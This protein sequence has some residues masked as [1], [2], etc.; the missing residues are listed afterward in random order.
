MNVRHWT[1]PA[2]GLSVLIHLTGLIWFFCQPSAGLKIL[3]ILAVN[4]LILSG[5]GL[6]P[7]S[8]A[9][10]PNLSR[11]PVTEQSQGKVV[12]TFDDGPDPEFTP[13]V[14]DILEAHGARGTF[15]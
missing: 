10:G 1:R 7:R 6:I 5:L 13:Q 4:H 8:R 11:L 12:L 3:L 2:V 15:L 14:L 9:L